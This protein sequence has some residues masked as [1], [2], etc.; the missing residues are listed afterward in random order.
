MTR[1]EI[2]GHSGQCAEI[3]DQHH[4]NY[5]EF[6]QLIIVLHQAERQL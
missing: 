3:I 2:G 5:M 1:H 6:V 4:Y